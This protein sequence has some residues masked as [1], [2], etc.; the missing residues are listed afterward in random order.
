MEMPEKRALSSPRAASCPGPGQPCGWDYY[1]SPEPNV[2]VLKGALV[3][4][5]DRNDNYNDDRTNFVVC[6]DFTESLIKLTFSQSNEVA[7]DYNAGFQS[8]VAGLNKARYVE[9][10]GKTWEHIFYCQL[11]NHNH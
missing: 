7:T 3:G 10:I 6:S 4:G 1:N 9:K 5:P 11:A 8:A 2:H